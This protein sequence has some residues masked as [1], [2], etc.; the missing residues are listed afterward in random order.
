MDPLFPALPEDLAALSD[1]DLATLLSE[2]EVAA[3]LIDADDEDFIK[4]MT[5][6][7]VMAAYD[8][9]VA[10]IK[11]IVAEQK[12]REEA[13]ENYTAEKEA[14]RKERL[15]A[16]GKADADPEGDEGDEGDG[17]AEGG[18]A[19]EAVAENADVVAEAE[20]ITAEAA[21]APVEEEAAE[22][23]VAVTA[24]VEKTKP[25]L[26]RPVPKPAADRMMQNEAGASLVAASGLQEVRAGQP[27]DPEALA[28]AMSKTAKR[29]GAPSKHERGTEERTL[30]ARADF[31]FPDELILT[32]NARDDGKKIKAVIPS[33][34]PWGDLRGQALTASGGLCAP[35]TPIYSMPNFASQAEPVWDSLPKFQADRGG[36]NVPAA[37]FLGDIVVNSAGGAITT[38]TE[39]NDALGGTFA[40]KTCQDLDCPVYTEVPVDIIAHCRDFGNLNAMA[41]PEMI[42][43]QNEL[44]MAAL[45]RT[46]ES[47]MLARIK[48]QSV[49]VTN[50][51]ETLGALIYLIDGIVKA[52]FGIQGRLRMDVNSQFRVLLPRILPDLLA[53]DTV[54]TPN[55]GRFNSAN[56]LVMYLQGYG[57]NPVFYLDTDGTGDSQIPD[58]SQ[59]AGA[60]D[61]L[62]DHIQWAIYPEGAFIGVDSGSL[63]LGIVRDSTLNSTNDFQI[64]GERFR[65]VARL[66]PA[67]GAYWVTSDL[68]ANGNFPPAGTSR[69]CD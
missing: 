19:E 48:A 20:E 64:F 54:Q 16:V 46:T 13:Q 44:T 7:E 28:N 12:T 58:S 40:T 59:A 63:E 35:L 50:G 41:W 27:L 37:P 30:I 56:D 25:A 68:C 51:A 67:Q 53:L 65:N 38:I 62:P 52:K 61:G 6:E 9:G 8:E 21:D 2:H 26:R 18:D 17:D 29:L 43:L 66:A 22:E 31:Q 45:A 15:E 33:S 32:G 11:A 23:K 1:E 39:A 10:Q 55:E 49:N 3:D 5:G 4:G 69:T 60:L 14:R 34:V 47:L 24:S 36:V 42:E 57:I